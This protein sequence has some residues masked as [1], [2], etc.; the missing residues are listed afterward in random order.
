MAV[1]TGVV[2]GLVPAL[3]TMKTN[4]NLVLRD[5]SARG[6][7]SRGTGVTRAGLVV[8]EVALALMLLVGAGLMV[9]S[10]THVQEVN[11]GSPP[12]TC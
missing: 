7:A 1:L 6:S 5:D 3:A 8:A 11:P 10:Y 9:K 2:F 4:V 12:T